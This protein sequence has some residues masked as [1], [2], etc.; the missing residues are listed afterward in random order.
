MSKRFVPLIIISI[1]I[2]TYFL[3]KA[4][5]PCPTTGK[6]SSFTWRGLENLDKNIDSASET[7]ISNRNL[8]IYLFDRFDFHRDDVNE[9]KFPYSE[10]NPDRG[11]LIRIPLHD[12]AET[13]RVNIS[14]ISKG[15]KINFA[16]N[17]GKESGMRVKSDGET[18]NSY[19]IGDDI[20]PVPPQPIYT[21]SYQENDRLAFESRKPAVFIFLSGERLAVIVR[22]RLIYDVTWN[23]IETLLIESGND[24]Q[25]QKYKLVSLSA[26]ESKEFSF[27]LDV[28]RF[29]DTGY[30]KPSINTAQRDHE[31]RLRSIHQ[32]RSRPVFILPPRTSLE[33]NII[34]PEAGCLEFD[35]LGEKIP[36]SP[37]TLI[38]RFL[39]E[40]KEIV[41][42]KEFA[43]KSCREWEHVK[44]DLENIPA[45]KQSL[46]FTAQYSKKA[47]MS[48]YFLISNVRMS[49]SKRPPGKNILLICLDTLRP[50][51]QG[52]YGYKKN[53][54]PNIDRLAEKGLVFTRCFSQSS[55][56][57]PSIA[58]LL[59]GKYPRTAVENLEVSPDSRSPLRLKDN[60]KTLSMILEENGY[61]TAAFT[62]NGWIHH[63]FGFDRGFEQYAHSEEPGSFKNEGSAEKTVED[64]L[65]WIEAN[66][67]GKWFVFFHTYEIHSPYIRNTFTA[68]PS[69]GKAAETIARYDSGIKYTD[70]QLGKLFTY[71]E[72][73]SLIENTIIIITSDHG[74]RFYN[75]KSGEVSDPR[76]GVHGISMHDE[77]I[78]VPLIIIPP[79]PEK[80]PAA[81]NSLVR[82]IDI[83]PT[84]LDMLDLKNVENLDGKSL[85]QP[86]EKQDPYAFT[87]S[88]LDKKAL[89]YSIRTDKYKLVK[90]ILKN[91]GEITYYLYD[92]KNDPKEK[93]NIFSTE[94][95]EIEG[96]KKI[97]RFY[98]NQ[99][100]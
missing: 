41:L 97:M 16:V 13:A 1:I 100:H 91:T 81:G 61:R 75:Y 18:L 95:S 45:G 96:L 70:E 9:Q 21:H 87:E 7:V 40:D 67:S 99:S 43:L 84:I 71:L 8:R 90:R 68:D 31:F 82:V 4:P 47:L 69:D 74:E 62:G 20:E 48:N 30:K 54:S 49:S 32:D 53:V 85:F 58:A 35:F 22:D 63:K 23:A 77:E 10:H 42:A 6:I 15:K 37:G 29:P 72:H 94:N 28:S 11:K 76:S 34:L 60:L 36:D 27:L 51:H 25:T 98:I 3:I 2:L 52:C 79:E 57:M 12:K 66:R 64:T 80:F 59:S 50:D 24:A 14:F 78:H 17:T 39:N 44:L 88:I 83:F 46:V 38:C 89:M 86:G 5:S 92:L 19:K 33:S 65:A 73:S 93:H 26:D 56:T 55:W